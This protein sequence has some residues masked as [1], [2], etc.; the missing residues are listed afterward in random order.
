MQEA[1]T[2]KERVKKRE[3]LPQPSVLMAIYSYMKNTLKS[4]RESIVVKNPKFLDLKE[5][6]SEIFDL[7]EQEKRSQ[8]VVDYEDLLFYAYRLLEENKEI[9]DREAERFLWVL[10]DEFQD[11]NYVQ[12]RIVE[13]LSSKHGNVLAVGDDAQSIYSFEGQGT[14]TLKIS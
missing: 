4:L 10:V 13:H 12:Y 6:I 8:N 7:Y 9:R 11:T 14:K 3:K 2:S 5:E 1:S